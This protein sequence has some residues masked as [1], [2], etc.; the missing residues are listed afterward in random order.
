MSI[1]KVKHTRNFTCIDNDVIRDRRLSLKAKG[2]HHLLLSYPSDWDVCILQLSKYCKEGR[3]A[4]TSGLKELISFGYCRRL[5]KRSPDGK[6]KDWD[7]EVYEYPMSEPL[8]GFPDLAEP[9]TGFPDLAKPLTG[10]PQQHNKDLTNTVL[11]KTLSSPTPSR[12]ENQIERDNFDEI[13][14]TDQL[15]TVEQIS[16]PCSTELA[17]GKITSS[18][19]VPKNS[20]FHNAGVLAQQLVTGQKLLTSSRIINIQLESPDG[21]AISYQ[22]DIADPDYRHWIIGNCIRKMKDQPER[23]SLNE[24]LL[25]SSLARKPETQ[26]RYAQYCQNQAERAEMQRLSGVNQIT[27]PVTPKPISLGSRC[28]MLQAKWMLGQTNVAFRKN[29]ISQAQEL[30]FI[31]DSQ[32]IRLPNYADP[33]TLLTEWE[34]F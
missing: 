24:D 28:A 23:N 7:Y 14:D 6:I 18:A 17:Q 27:T 19:A 16:A 8:T 29:A 11:T 13:L 5:V 33:E 20:N 21:E 10:F 4:I 26:R 22:L 32:G 2:L 25:V 15:P 34:A 3:E 1:I 12:P 30:G 31:V 9:F